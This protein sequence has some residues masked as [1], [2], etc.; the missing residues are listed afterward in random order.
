[1][2]RGKGRGRGRGRG[3]G[4]GGEGRRESGK[5]GTKIQ[6]LS[7]SH[8]GGKGTELSDLCLSQQWFLRKTKNF[9]HS[10]FRVGL[11]VS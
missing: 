9:R 3:G 1:V 10:V 5:K 4:G 8:L 2:R 11:H 6:C 7:G